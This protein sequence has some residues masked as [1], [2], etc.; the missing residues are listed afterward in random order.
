MG[1]MEPKRSFNTVAELYDEAR[2]TYPEAASEA[3]LAVLPERGRIL[4]VGCGTG[5]ATRPFA[6]R[7][8]HIVALELGAALAERAAVKLRRFPRVEVVR[9]AFEAWQAPPGGFDLLL[10]AQAFHW[11]DPTFG[12]RRATEVLRSGGHVALMWNLDESQKTDFY[13]ATDPIYQRHYGPPEESTWTGYTAM[14]AR[15]RRA[16]EATGAFGPVVEH[17]FPWRARY[18][19]NGY[20]KLV[21]TFSPT[22]SLPEPQQRRFL[23]ELGEVV[24]AFGGEVTR[25][26]VT[27]V[28]LA[29]RS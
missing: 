27:T 12:A 1:F 11:I 13:R 21:A 14:M 25:F 29:G 20:L 8:H 22:L 18:D 24:D 3:I 23:A 2:P 10:S 9:T 5:Q 6:E 19:R 7:G 15:Y 17:R 4:E 26:Y 16:L 28:L